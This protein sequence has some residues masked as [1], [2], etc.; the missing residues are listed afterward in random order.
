MTK[1]SEN[2]ETSN[3]TKPVLCVVA[4]LC[5]RGK[6]FKEFEKNNKKDNESFIWIY[7]YKQVLGRQFDRIE[8]VRDWYE[9]KNAYE[10][11]EGIQIRLRSNYA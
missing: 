7:D 3:S 1:H 2:T 10:I 9:M 8:K 6:E 4:V 5:L 11:L